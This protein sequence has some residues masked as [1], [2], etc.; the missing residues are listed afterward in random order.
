M[1]IVS[2]RVC[3]YVRTYERQLAGAVGVFSLE[4]DKITILKLKQTTGDRPHF[5]LLFGC[6]AGQ[7]S[8]DKVIG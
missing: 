7:I 8:R 1:N 4:Q 5:F 6:L 2:T 3:M